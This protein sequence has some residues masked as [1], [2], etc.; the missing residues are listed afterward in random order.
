M[1]IGKN[2]QKRRWVKLVILLAI[3]ALIKVFSLFGGWVEAGYATG[4]YP[5]I[6]TVMRAITGWLPISIGDLFYAFV[7]IWLVIKLI[8]IIRVI[9]RRKATWQGFGNGVLKATIRVLYIYIAFNILW[10]LN[11]NRYGISYQL[12]LKQQHYT[13]DEL[14]HIT[15]LLIDKVNEK[16]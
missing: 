3:A 9:V 15:A 5:V 13:T 6:A 11:Y 7:F 16:R 12:R 1:P 2:G 4:I 14:K 10:G 8:K